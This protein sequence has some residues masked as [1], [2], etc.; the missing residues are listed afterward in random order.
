MMADGKRRMRL[1]ILGDQAF[2]KCDGKVVA[3]PTVERNGDYLVVRFEMTDEE[4]LR[5]CL[6]QIP[7]QPVEHRTIAAIKSHA[8]SPLRPL[9]TSEHACPRCGSLGPRCAYVTPDDPYRSVNLYCAASACRTVWSVPASEVE[10]PFAGEPDVPAQ[11]G[12]LRNPYGLP[13]GSVEIGG[14]WPLDGVASPISD[15]KVGPAVTVSAAFSRKFIDAVKDADPAPPEPKRC[16]WCRMELLEG[17]DGCCDPCL[18]YAKEKGVPICDLIRSN[19]VPPHIA[20]KLAAVAGVCLVKPE[21]PTSPAPPEPTQETW[22]DR[23]PLL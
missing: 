11:G 10:V 18:A 21:P 20:D 3:R 8:G 13:P 16:Q 2:V 22:R 14:P 1:E 4:D 23:P 19:V 15:L 12:T 5:P 17:R 9:T 7:G 6:V